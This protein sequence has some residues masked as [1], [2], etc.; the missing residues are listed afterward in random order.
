MEINDG[1]A[2]YGDV[3]SHVLSSS[4]RREWSGLYTELRAHSDFYLPSFVQKTTEVA[5][6]LRGGGKVTHRING[7]LHKT[8]GAPGVIW[9]FG[10][11]ASVDFLHASH[12]F[13][14]GSQVIHLYLNPEL[15]SSQA[16]GDA[17]DESLEADL[18]SF[19]G[20]RDPLIEQIGR[21]IVA[22]M[23]AETSSGKL[24]VEALTSTLA[25]RLLHS[26]TWSAGDR[27]PAL[28]V[29]KGLDSQRLRRV[30]DFIEANLEGDLT[31]ERMASIACL[32]R[33]Y[34][35]RAFKA[36]TGQSPHQYVSVRRLERAKSLILGADRSLADIADSLNFSSH[37]NFTRA[38]RRIVG[39]TPS[40][41][42]RS[43]LA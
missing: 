13:S 10:D 16:L 37:A 31:I 39:Q 1:G 9:L 6:L 28:S 2:K 35:A 32:S 8:S 19:G 25:A 22:E 20:F 7:D 5:L 27:S 36:S 43:G 23:E 24:F 11:K 34:F 4:S 26:Y 41:F 38:F 14:G 17:A 42:R 3:T 21:A 29:P 18:K 15:F 40:Q 12:A 33:F 30:L